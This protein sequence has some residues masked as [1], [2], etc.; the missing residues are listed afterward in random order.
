MQ[1]LYAISYGLC[2][3]LYGILGLAVEDLTI[4]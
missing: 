4:M 2:N 3:K 1:F